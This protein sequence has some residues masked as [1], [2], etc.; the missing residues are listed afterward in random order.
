MVGISA[1]ASG[2]PLLYL[3]TN[4]INWTSQVFGVAATGR[5]PLFYD[6]TYYYVGDT[7]ATSVGLLWISTNGTTWT[8]RAGLTGSQ[9]FTGGYSATA[10]F[11]YWI[12]GTNSDLWMSTNGTTWATRLTTPSNCW[13]AIW[14][15][16]YYVAVGSS[17]F[18][19]ISTNGTTWAT[20][21]VAAGT[22]FQDVTYANGYYV[23]PN[24]QAGLLTYVST[25]GLN[26][27]T[28]ASANNA[29]DQAIAY[30]RGHYIVGNSTNNASARRSTTNLT[31]YVS[32]DNVFTA[33][34]DARGFATNS[35]GTQIVGATP[36]Q[37]PNI[38]ML[39]SNDVAGSPYYAAGVTI[40]AVSLTAPVVPSTY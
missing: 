40:T 33:A 12:T 39:Y 7:Q 36:Y 17:S 20:R 1:P 21:A 9:A 35:A 19:A 4:G 2:N 16:P 38:D 29:N 18:L 14:Q 8:T 37:T 15:S 30:I 13:K 28:R 5:A 32:R 34:V 6:G 22:E 3:S 10:P 24:N 25:D 11:K 23:A 27:T 31:N 26:W